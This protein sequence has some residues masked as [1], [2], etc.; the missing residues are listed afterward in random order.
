MD[1]ERGYT[2]LLSYE[3]LANAIEEAWEQAGLH[4]H[5]VNETIN[6]ATLERTFR[7]EIFPDHGEPL[8]EQNIPPWVELSFVW[9][10]E[11]QRASTANTP[12]ALE[13]LWNYTITLAG[14]DK[15]SDLELLK[16]FA[17]VVNQTIRKLFQQAPDHDMLAVEIRRSYQSAETRE[18]QH[19][20]IYASGGSD[21]SELFISKSADMLRT[22]LHEEMLV[23]ASLLRALAEAFSPGSV[24]G[25]RTVES[26]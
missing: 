1:V 22:V 13:L 12:V 5:G 14:H 15:R 7:A 21:I 23:V 9:D 11:H 16:A 4:E 10:A 26:A 6:P 19:I 8:T 2:T 18:L 20:V 25:Y 17:T 24:G 3:E